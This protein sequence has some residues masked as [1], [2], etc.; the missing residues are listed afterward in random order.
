M[1]NLFLMVALLCLNL[2]AWS[3]EEQLLVGVAALDMQP[4]VGI[5]LAGYGS[6]DRRLSNFFD[7]RSQYSESSLFKPS[8][9]Y[10][11]AI[12]SKV[13]VLKKGE[14]E[15]IFISLDT[16]GTEHRFIKDIAK[17]LKKHGIQEKDLIVSATHTHGGPG[18]LSK[19]VPLMAIAVDFY[20]NK[21][22]QHILSKVVMSVEQ[23]LQNLRPANLYKT[24]AVINGVQKN[25]WRRKDE[26]HFDKNASFL[27]AR[28]ALTNEW[29]GGL[30]NFS[31]HGGTMPI[32]L[33]LY[34][35]DVNGAIEKELENYFAAENGFSLTTPAILFMNGAE[36][37]VD[38]NSGRSVEAVD[39]LAKKFIQE[40]APQLDA[41]WTPVTPEFSAV[42]KKIFVGIPG[43]PL[44]CQ[45]GLFKNLPDWVKLK[46]YPLLPARSYISQA[47][48]G[49]ILY[50]TWPGEP[51]TQM[52]YDLQAMAR[53][54]G[55][56]DPIVLGLVNDY[57]TYFTTKSEYA[58]KAY[59]SCS[60]IY[61]WQGGE[62]ILKAHAKLLP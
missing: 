13:M 17:K 38:G 30:V 7:W 48:V 9:G 42:K 36:G 57:M 10:H 23:A 43:V 44:N 20:R 6:T 16:I 14:R 33:M 53:A 46:I 47:T 34:S 27:M 32:P 59:D 15:L 60:S 51:S 21:N 25:K 4:K 18:T 52:G 56:S 8:E 3:Q 61:G 12:R 24:K 62:R 35:S 58:E 31:I 19:R 50:L 41:K 45:G 5:P 28:D 54:R 29:M 55:A 37:D 2:S 26:E 22:Y 1:K 39:L 49:D 40:A 11:S